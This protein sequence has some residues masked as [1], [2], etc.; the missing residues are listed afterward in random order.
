M[1]LEVQYTSGLKSVND[2]QL[3]MC[4]Y[5]YMCVCACVRVSLYPS[6]HPSIHL[7]IHPS[8]HL[9]IYPS[10]HISTFIHLSIYLSIFLSYQSINQSI[11]LSIYLSIDRSIDLS[12]YPCALLAKYKVPQPNALLLSHFATIWLNWT[13]FPQPFLHCAFPWHMIYTYIHIHINT[14]QHNTIHYATAQYN[15]IHTFIDIYIYMYMY[16]CTYMSMICLATNGYISI[17]YMYSY[18]PKINR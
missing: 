10:I 1:G 14:I 9:S 3:I 8:I 15:T 4:I 2:Q 5:I 6:I 18:W 12:I 16:M 7:S 17:V 13:S 11:N